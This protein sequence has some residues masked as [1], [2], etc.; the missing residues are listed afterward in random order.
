MVKS[1]VYILEEAIGS[2][3]PLCCYVGF[4]V[5]TCPDKK[6]VVPNRRIG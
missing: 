5:T 1:I 4:S 6:V 2:G 3:S